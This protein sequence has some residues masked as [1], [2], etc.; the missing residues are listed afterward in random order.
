V[1]AYQITGPAW[2]AS[3][4]FDIVAKLPAGAS[5]DDA[6]AML[7]ELL[8]ERF[9][10]VT[11]RDTK[12]HPVLALVIGKDGPKLKES[13]VAAV[14]VAEDAPLKPGEMKMDTADG[15]AR[16]TQNANGSVTWNMGAKGTI[17]QKIDTQTQ[18]LHMESSTVTMEG[19][20]DMLTNMLQTSGAGRQVVDMTGLK[21]NYQVA[22]DISL[23][24]IMSMARANGIDIPM[25]AAGGGTAATGA[26]LP[27]A[28]EPN[29]GSTVFASVEKLGLKLE[30]RKAAVEQ[31][32]V[33]SAEKLPTEN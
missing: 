30:Q 10:L 14:P 16:A 21:G 19:F 15:Q 24:D 5:K 23:A 13:P 18:T 1:K 20:A 7:Q 32:V 31:L 8:Q 3:Q 2:L 25:P 9:K 28:S 11:H 12:E 27:E 29:G 6:P 17:T 26:T 4:R 33:D 22:V